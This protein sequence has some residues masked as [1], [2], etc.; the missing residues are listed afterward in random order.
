MLQCL[1]DSE[2][3]VGHCYHNEMM[4]SVMEKLVNKCKYKSL[5]EEKR[6]QNVWT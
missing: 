5:A 3:V 4:V 2:L 6:Y 1:E